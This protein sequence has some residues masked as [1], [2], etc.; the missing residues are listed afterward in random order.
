[1][2]DEERR[3]ITL[4]TEQIAFTT[5]LLSE[6]PYYNIEGSS[7]FKDALNM[8]KSKKFTV[9]EVNDMK[10]LIADFLFELVTIYNTNEEELAAE[11]EVIKSNEA[12][13]NLKE[14][15]EVFSDNF[16]VEEFKKVIESINDE[17]DAHICN[18]VSKE[19][20]TFRKLMD[21][22][23]E[24]LVNNYSILEVIKFV[25][26]QVTMGSLLSY[27]FENGTLEN[28]YG[29]DDEEDEE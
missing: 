24:I 26:K 7:T 13:K 19:Y 1:M 3:Q 10:E 15:E 11:L 6:F 5:I 25:T 23:E 16:T 18:F 17:N 29:D 27:F 20:K 21:G 8:A 4:S 9:Q 28:I 12:F 2:A 22:Y 14:Y